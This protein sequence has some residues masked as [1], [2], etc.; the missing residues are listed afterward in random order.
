MFIC[1]QWYFESYKVYVKAKKQFKTPWAVVTLS[2][3]IIYFLKSVIFSLPV[4]VIK[5]TINF[6]DEENGNTSHLNRLGL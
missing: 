5:I 6:N 3:I 4:N 1:V 2:L